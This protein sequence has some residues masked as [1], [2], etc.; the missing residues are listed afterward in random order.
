[1]KDDKNVMFTFFNGE[2]FDYIGSSKMMYDMQNNKFPKEI[3]TNDE[4]QVQWPLIDIESIRAHI[5][6]GQLFNHDNLNDIFAHVDSKADNE[7]LINLVT[8]KAS[9]SGLDVKLSNS[10]KLPPASIQT[11]LKVS[12]RSISGTK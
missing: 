6:V 12:N 7:D 4:G 8:S 11:T 2:A 1:M 3:I 5:E 9:E 10:E